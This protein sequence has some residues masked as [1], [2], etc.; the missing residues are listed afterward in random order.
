[1][2]AKSFSVPKGLLAEPSDGTLVAAKGWV[3]RAPARTLRVLR[4]LHPGLDAV[5]AMDYSFNVERMTPRDAGS[6]AIRA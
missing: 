5:A 1:M 2:A 4:R 6:S 3:A